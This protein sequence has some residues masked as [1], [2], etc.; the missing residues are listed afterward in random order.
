MSDNKDGVMIAEA[1]AEPQDTAP[2]TLA[3]L[4]DTDLSPKEVE[5]AQK[6]HM[7]EDASAGTAAAATA[8]DTTKVVE[9]APKK[10]DAAPLKVLEA[11]DDPE[12]EADLIKDFNKN[13][14]GLYFKQKKERAQRQT[15]EVERDHLAIK[16]KAEQDRAARLEE[17]NK[18][19]KVPKKSEP[20]LDIYGNPVEEEKKD[21]DEN[22]PV[23][24]KDLKEIEKEKTEKAKKEED[25]N[26]ARMERAQKLTGVLNAQEA[27][28][29]V[30]YGE[31]FKPAIVLATKILAAANS[32]SLD[33]IFGG[34]KKAASRALKL[35]IDFQYATANA[36][37]IPEGEYNAADVAFEL[38]KMH[39][40]FGKPNGSGTETPKKDGA[41]EPEKAKRAID[42][43]SKR[44]S[45]AALPSG[46]GNRFV[47]YE[48]M[49]AAQLAALP[50]T[51]FAKVPREI[52]QRILQSA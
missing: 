21:D 7:V 22:K 30:V 8:K 45:S 12:K 5:L 16:L 35:C 43:A 47:P 32:K 31:P 14:K 17:E 23:T 29:E 42:N 28:G 13:E 6:H 38:G 39:P 4:A 24:I 52:R 44:G 2:I 18:T 26:A 1:K 10:D 34:D 51:E 40:E 27:E 11:M 19:L 33:S 15:A 9:T 25:D 36:D 20:K 3:E 41:I 49:D 46:G 48:E 50:Q 37:R